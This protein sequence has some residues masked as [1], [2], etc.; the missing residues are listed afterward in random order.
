MVHMPGA[1]VTVCIGGACLMEG[2]TGYETLSV[3]RHPGLWAKTRRS[4]RTISTVRGEKRP[5]GSKSRRLNG[6]GPEGRVQG[7]G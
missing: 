5:G 4:G 6:Q 1:I 3:I 2:E 7:G